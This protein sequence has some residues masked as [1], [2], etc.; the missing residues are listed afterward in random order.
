MRRIAGVAVAV[1]AVLVAMT[2]G[3]SS[4]TG[5]TATTTTSDATAALWDPC[6]QIP[7]SALRAAQLDPSTKQSG[8]GGVEQHGWKI[9]AWDSNP[10]KYAISVYST[11]KAPA[12]I[13]GKSGNIGQKD[14]TIVGR[15][16]TEF[17]SSGWDTQCNV[18]FPAAQGAVQLQMLGR[19]SED[20][21]EDP[22]VMLAR[23]GDAIVPL[24][25]K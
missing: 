19:L 20:N 15:T 24:L 17:R 10:K 12:E 6:T 13:A 21:P 5:G 3:C 11:A 16:G 1:G 7:D 25:P 8:I 9:C 14:V 18:V 22:C 2:A 4:T 23:V